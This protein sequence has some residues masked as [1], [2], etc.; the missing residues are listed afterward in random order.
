MTALSLRCM[1]TVLRGLKTCG[2]RISQDIKGPTTHSLTLQ[3]NIIKSTTARVH[4]GRLLQARQCSI[5]CMSDF[6]DAS[7]QPQVAGT[8]AILPFK[9]RRPREANLPNR[10]GTNLQHPNSNLIIQVCWHLHHLLL[11]HVLQCQQELRVFQIMLILILHLL[12][13]VQRKIKQP[14]PF[15]GEDCPA[16]L[17]PWNLPGRQLSSVFHGTSSSSLASSLPHPPKG[18]LDPCKCQVSAHSTLGDL[19]QVNFLV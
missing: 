6:I 13:I 1:T 5:S 3:G 10:K 18:Q 16:E 17:P 4:S 9:E 14:R 12:V 19:R 8:I 15:H 2:K 11:C 7:H